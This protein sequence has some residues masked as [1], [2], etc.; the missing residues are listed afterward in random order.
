MLVGFEIYR[1]PDSLARFVSFAG[2]KG[3]L[4][5]LGFQSFCEEFPRGVPLSNGMKTK[6]RSPLLCPMYIARRLREG[7]H[8]FFPIS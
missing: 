2:F 4:R 1:T 8:A 7:K 5:W 3:F 6:G